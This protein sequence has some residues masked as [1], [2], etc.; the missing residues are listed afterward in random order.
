MISCRPAVRCEGHG[1]LHCCKWTEGNLIT[2]S[3][4]VLGLPL[5]RWLVCRNRLLLT[6]IKKALFRL[7][8]SHHLV[9]ED[10]G[11]VASVL[12]VVRLE[13]ENVCWPWPNATSSA[14]YG[15]LWVDGRVEYTHRL[16][17]TEATGRPPVGVV[18]HTCDNPPCN[19]PKHLR[20]GTKRQNTWDS[21]TRLRQP[22]RKLDWD[23]VHE[24]RSKSH[25]PQRELAKQ[26]GVSQRL[27]LNVLK[28]R[29][30]P[31]G[32]AP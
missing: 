3:R 10:E 8:L 25:L 4:P 31:E 9:R 28:G 29:A 17:F 6:S 16:A 12:E 21:L 26:Y 15:Q 13:D 18:R 7:V 23:T 20:D 32:A 27:I 24:I 14:G 1:L 5:F 22:K 2:R 11:P 30:W 19:N